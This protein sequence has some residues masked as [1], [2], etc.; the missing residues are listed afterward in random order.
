MSGKTTDSFF[1]Y[2]QNII[3]GYAPWK[4]LKNTA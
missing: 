1:N 2:P 3:C 4:Q